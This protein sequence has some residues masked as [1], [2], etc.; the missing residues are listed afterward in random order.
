[1][2]YSIG[3]LL[4]WKDTGELS[5]I[6]EYWKDYDGQIVYEIETYIEMYDK[7]QAETIREEK[8]SVLIEIY[9]IIEHYPVK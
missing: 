1:M 8:I 4:Y 6:I 7:R 3:D 9:D 2:K 5:T